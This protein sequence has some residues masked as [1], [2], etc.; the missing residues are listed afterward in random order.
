MRT[1]A[2]SVAA[3]LL[4]AAFGGAAWAV[5]PVKPDL[6]AGPHR[7]WSE[8]KGGEGTPRGT[9]ETPKPPAASGGAS[10]PPAP[11]ATPEDAHVQQL[12][13]E[14]E[15]RATESKDKMKKKPGYKEDVPA[16][17]AAAPRAN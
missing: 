4:A 3:G 17:R 5:D 13:E 8:M 7:D 6:G 12:R 15:R 16:P 10:A 2:T 9:V 14:D 11:A 1:L